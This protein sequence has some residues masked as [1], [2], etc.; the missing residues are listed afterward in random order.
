MGSVGA[1]SYAVKRASQA[2]GPFNLLGTVSASELRTYSDTPPNGVWFYQVAAQGAG[3]QGAGSNVV[4]IAVPGERRLVMPLN[5]SNGPGT[6]GTLLTAAGTLTSIQGTLLDGATWGD[7]RRN[8]KAI[9]F[10]GQKAGLQLPSGVF[11]D[12]D[13]FSLSFWAYANGL[14]WDSCVFYAGLD[15]NAAMC[16]APQTLT[17]TLCFSIF[18]AT[19]ND[20]QVVAAPWAMPTRRWVHVA[21]TLRGNTC[22]LYVDG[23]EAGRSDDIVLSPRQIGDQV[24]FLGRNWAHPSFNGRIQD[25]RV[26]AGA[27]SAAEVAVLAQ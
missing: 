14:H 13:D 16:I 12:L 1:T 6:V 4:R 27:L 8:D 23:T 5:D 9:A 18:G 20:A 17:G 22:R 15:A 2:N 3:A 7:G 10:D 26:Y 21:V 24:T 25:F 11:S 19:G